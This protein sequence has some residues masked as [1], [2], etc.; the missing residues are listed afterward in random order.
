MKTGGPHTNGVNTYAL[1]RTRSSCDLEA[2]IQKARQRYETAR[3]ESRRAEQ[4]VANHTKARRDQAR[5]DDRRALLVGRVLMRLAIDKPE[6]WSG[7][8]PH[9]EKY[10]QTESDANR[11]L[12]GL[13]PLPRTDLAE[14]SSTTERPNDG[15]SSDNEQARPE[16][17][18]EQLSEKPAMPV[19]ENGEVNNPAS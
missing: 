1:D 5:E 6:T 7:I 19:Q 11:A 18:A 10:L 15:S 8:W 13:P 17:H 12:F 16:S 9:V 4:E 2:A 14:V 3:T